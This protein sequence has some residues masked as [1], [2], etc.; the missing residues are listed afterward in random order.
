M[1][2]ATKIK[3]R[4]TEQ[5]EKDL[6]STDYVNGK[7]TFDREMT[8]CVVGYSYLGILKSFNLGM[9]VNGKNLQTARKRISEFVLRFVRSA[10][11]N[12][13]TDLSALQP[14]QYFSPSGFMDLPPSP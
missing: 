2:N 5:I 8:S 6:D 12:V 1:T 4:I 14:V 9:A 13:G 7:I 10:G 3:Q 11:G